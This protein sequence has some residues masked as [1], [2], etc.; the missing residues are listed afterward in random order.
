[1]KNSYLLSNAVPHFLLL[2]TG[3]DTKFSVPDL[4]DSST[5]K[6]FSA[7]CIFKVMNTSSV[8]EL[9]F[10]DKLLRFNYSRFTLIEK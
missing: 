8:G 2:V 3:I 10:K 7:S 1:M 6:L 4:W 9:H 5:G